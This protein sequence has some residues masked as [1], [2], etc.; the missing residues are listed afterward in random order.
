MAKT[1]NTH[2]VLRNDTS[3]NWQAHSD[4]VLLK[5]EI[6]IEFLPNGEKKFKI[7]DGVT[8]WANLEYSDGAFA[9]ENGGLLAAI[10]QEKI[11]QWNAAQPNTIAQ[12]FVNGSAV[13]IID[14]KVDI[15][16]PTKASDIGAAAVDHDHDGIYL[17]ANEMIPAALL[18]SFVDDVIEVANFD[19]LPEAGEA[20]KIYVVVDENVTYRWSG[21]TYVKMS[22]GTALG[23]TAD[24]AFRGDL[25]KIAYDHALSDHAPATA[26][27]NI[28]E[29]FK[30]AG[31]T[32]LVEDKTVN[33]PVA[34]DTN[35]GVV[36]SSSGANKVSV[37]EDGTMSVGIVSTSSLRVPEGESLILDGGSASS[38]IL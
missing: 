13:S 6:G 35:F 16:I 11:D 29:V 28:I 21:T 22:G 3:A 31:E 7:G 9:P 30:V 15:A 20:G 14:K 33:I 1:I 27:E 5:G 4:Q 17:K 25:G 38:T 18:P 32:L 19:A 12:I 34:S 37:A 2:I 24:T 26:Q 8:S 23:E 36:K 10:T